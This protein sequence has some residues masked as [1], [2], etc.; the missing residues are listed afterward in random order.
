MEISIALITI[1]Q[2]FYSAKTFS[3]G[4]KYFLNKWIILMTCKIVT[5]GMVSEK[6]ELLLMQMEEAI[7]GKVE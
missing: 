6:T 1:D 3:I 2:C 7:A 4:K 5:T